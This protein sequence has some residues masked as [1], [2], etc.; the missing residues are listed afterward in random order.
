VVRYGRVS[1]SDSGGRMGH[2]ERSDHHVSEI[3][4]GT[5]RHVP[6]WIADGEHEG[7]LPVGIAVISASARATLRSSWI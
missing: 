2:Y 5:R 7:G 3:A 6:L 1:L 4:A